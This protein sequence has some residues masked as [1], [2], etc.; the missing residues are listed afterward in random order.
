MGHE[1]ITRELLNQVQIA[2]GRFTEASAAVYRDLGVTGA[3][4]QVL[5][6]I[7]ATG[8][9]ATVPHLARFEGVSRQHVQTLADR[10][11]DRGLIV[12]EPNPLHARSPLVILTPKGR[13][14]VE[15][16][17]ECEDALV[18]ELASVLPSDVATA[19]AVLRRLNAAFHRRR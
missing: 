4:K 7:A 16:V 3:M 14:V 9:R 8:R 1:D 10:L 18:A 12:F 2:A 17:R 13:A 11:A 19:L 6:R 15:T 5:A